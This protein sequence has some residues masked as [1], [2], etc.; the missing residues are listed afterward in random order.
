MNQ[1][2]EHWLKQFPPPRPPA[3]LRSRIFRKNREGE[4]SSTPSVSTPTNDLPPQASGNV[5]FVLTSADSHHGSWRLTGVL[6]TTGLVLLTLLAFLSVIPRPDGGEP[7]M[8]ESPANQVEP[9]PHHGMELGSDPDRQTPTV[10]KADDLVACVVGFN[11]VVW[12]DENEAYVMHQRLSPGDRISIESGRLTLVFDCGVQMVLEGPADLEIAGEKRIRMDTGII[13]ARAWTGGEGFTIDTPQVNVVDLSTEFGVKVDRAGKTDVAVFEGAIDVFRQ[14]P[15]S[16][17]SP[18]GAT[19]ERLSRGDVVRFEGTEGRGASRPQEI[20]G[21]NSESFNMFEWHDRVTSGNR[22]GVSIMNLDGIIVD[23]GRANCSGDWICSRGSGKWV[24]DWYYHDMKAGQGAKS[25]RFAV[26]LPKTGRYEVRMSYSSFVENSRFKR[27]S[28][29]P[30]DI[31]TSEGIKR[32]RLDQRGVPPIDGL[33]V[34]LGVFHFDATRP[35]V[36]TVSNEGADGFVTA[37]AIQFLPI[38]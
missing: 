5:D 8:A 24:G 2:F 13:T 7:K 37:D 23:A 33:F 28:N 6:A 20:R 14:E 21:R 35:A 12:R 3:N 32:T 19:P 9:V 29:V 31:E 1:D 38:P 4:D 15:V 36:V 18:T 11:S 27:A 16:K 17:T 10:P 30:I 25:I 22:S 26:N 34:S